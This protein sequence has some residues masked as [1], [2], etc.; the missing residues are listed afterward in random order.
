MDSGVAECDVVDVEQDLVGALLV[1]HL[2]AG[3]P[4]VSQDHPDRGLGPGRGRSMPVAVTVRRRRACNPVACKSVGD[5]METLAGE[6]LIEDASHQV[7]CGRIWFEPMQAAAEYA[8]T[9]AGR[10]TLAGWLATASQP[11]TLESEHLLKVFFAEHGTK[12]DLLATISALRDWADADLAVH[13]T[14]A[15][16]YLAGLG[17]FQHRAPVLALTARYLFDLADMTRQWADWATGVVDTWPE[18]ITAAEPAWE[19]FHAVV[20]R[21]DH[22]PARRR[23]RPRGPRS[24]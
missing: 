22:E 18:G 11:P 17:P 5:E 24:A 4:G 6:E 23:P 3:V 16:T 15:R 19:A 20:E 1:P 21:G 8:I 2:D 9:D 10:R 14:V 7:L 12:A 13:A